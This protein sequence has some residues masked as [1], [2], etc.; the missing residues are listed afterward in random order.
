MKKTKEPEL[1]PLTKV[2]KRQKLIGYLKEGYSVQKAMELA[3]YSETTIRTK[4][5]RTVGRNVDVNA[6]H[7]TSKGRSLYVNHLALDVA[8]DMMDTKKD[9]KTRSY[10]AKLAL[11]NAKIHLGQDRTPLSTTYKF[12]QINVYKNMKLENV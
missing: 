11:D 10:G 3:G 6:L 5:R 9:D 2:E 8:E 12:T 4:L 7:S 1:K